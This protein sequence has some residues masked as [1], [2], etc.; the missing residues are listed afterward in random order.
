MS[1]SS[2]VP[3]LVVASNPIP[4][5]ASDEVYFVVRHVLAWWDAELFADGQAQS[6]SRFLRRFFHLG[7]DST[8]VSVNWLAHHTT[9]QHVNRFVFFS[10]AR[11]V[12][13]QGR[14]FQLHCEEE[15]LVNE[16]PFPTS[17]QTFY[18]CPCETDHLHFWYANTVLG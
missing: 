2:R 16:A 14:A 11:M 10:N 17:P 8:F 7:M 12:F 3:Q 9:L 4:V 5:G 6:F 18:T 15:G 1:S 13:L